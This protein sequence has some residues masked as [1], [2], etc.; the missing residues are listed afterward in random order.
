MLATIG[1]KIGKRCHISSNRSIK[2]VVPYLRVIFQNS[3]EM[4]TGLTTWFEF[5]EDMTNYLSANK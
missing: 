3:K 5:D 2:E 1:A 4:K